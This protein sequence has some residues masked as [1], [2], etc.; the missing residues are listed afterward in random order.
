[1][2]KVSELTPQ[3]KALKT[4]NDLDNA[5]TEMNKFISD[6]KVAQEQRYEAVAKQLQLRQ[7]AASVRVKLITEI[8]DEEGPAVDDIVKG[9]ARAKKVAKKIQGIKDMLDFIASAI[10]FF[11][12]LAEGKVGMIKTAWKDFEDAMDKLEKNRPRMLMSTT[13]GKHSSS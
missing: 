4:A 11:A 6:P 10:L 5:A 3:E 2:P 13:A 8:A 12:A 7:Q 9:A 1:M